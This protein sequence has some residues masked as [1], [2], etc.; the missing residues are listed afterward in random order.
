MSTIKVNGQDQN[1]ELPYSIQDV[2]KSNNVFQPEM[3][4][5]QLNGEFVAKDSYQE[6]LLNENDEVDFLYFMGGGS[7]LTKN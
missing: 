6:T 3:V 2:I 5:I 4:S 7:G 1:V